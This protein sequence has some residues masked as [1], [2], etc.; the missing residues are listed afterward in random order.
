MTVRALG[1]INQHLHMHMHYL[2]H[3]SHHLDIARTT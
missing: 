3:C 1:P 2:E